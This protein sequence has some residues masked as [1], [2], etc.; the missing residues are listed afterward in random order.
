[1][2]YTTFFLCLMLPLVT[3]AQRSKSKTKII[4]ITTSLNYHSP[5]T[6]YTF[7]NSLNSEDDQLILNYLTATSGTFKVENQN[8]IIIERSYI[9]SLPSQLINLGCG[10]QF[11][12]DNGRFHEISF[13]G[14][15]LFK[16]EVLIEY[17]RLDSL[18][19]SIF[20]SASGYKQ[21]TFSISFRYEFGKYF[22]NEESDIRFG[23]GGG[24]EPIFYSYRRD[25]YALREYPVS[26][27]IIQINLAVIPMLRMQISEK[28]AFEMK[29]VPNLRMGNFEKVIEQNP[30][31]LDYQKKG[32]GSYDLPDF[33]MAFSLG[34]KYQIHAKKK[35]R[36]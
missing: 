3:Q 17:N 12:G 14:L 10:V 5:L 28:V 20:V 11:I 36:R 24:I 15:S 7:F 34:L 30:V 6:A 22:G 2:K 18:G 23:I 9:N 27:S 21:R 16:S 25:P 1:M 13:T 19:N 26:A 8:P 33:E 32:E 31:L 35:R 29:V 4:D